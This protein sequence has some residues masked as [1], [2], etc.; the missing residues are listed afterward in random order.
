MFKS[1][2]KLFIMSIPLVLAGCLDCLDNSSLSENQDDSQLAP[3]AVPHRGPVPII[4]MPPHP[5]PI[6]VPEQVLVQPPIVQDQGPLYNPP[7]PGDLFLPPPPPPASDTETDEDKT[8]PT[9]TDPDETET[10]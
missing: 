8:C 6:N 10:H 3:I 4:I 7:H 5:V 2:T 1:Y 9:T